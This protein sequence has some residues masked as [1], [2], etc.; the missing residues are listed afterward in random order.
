MNRT[1]KVL[2]AIGGIFVLSYPGIA[3]VT[4]MT[5]ESRMQHSEQQA[6]DQVPYLTLVKREYDRGVYRSTEVATYGLHLPVPTGVKT[7]AGAALFPAATVT[8]VSRIQ[9]GPFPGLHGPALAVIDSTFIAPPAV[10]KELAGALGSKPLL[11]AHTTVG[12][13]GGATTDL[14]SPAF[15]LVLGPDSTLA[16]EGLTG[17]FKTARHLAA[18]SG[19]LSIPR[20]VFQS[21]QG[22]IQL[23]GLE[24]SGSHEKA[25]DGLYLGTGTLTLERLGAGSASPGGGFSLQR[26]SVTT[27][28]K[29]EG[30]F[31]D[32]RVDAAADA[33]KVA[34]VQLKNV[35]YSE[36]LEHLH[37]PSF[38]SMAQAIRK[39]EQQAGTNQ[40]QAQAGIQDAIRQ[41]GPDLLSHDPVLDIRQ[42]SFA[43]PEGSF[44]LAAK[45]SAPGLS[46]A[47][48][49]W[50]A[51]ILALRTHAQV[52]ADLKVDNGLVQKLLTMGGANPKI[53]AQLTSFEQ[54]GYLTAGSS[55]VTTHLEYSGGRLT[56]N[57][58][59]FPP[60]APVN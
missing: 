6:L 8:I 57:G 53:A 20:F 14:T 13:F 5:I 54:Q 26:L 43:M 18:W 52:T 1:T 55:A 7:A 29:A 48:L 3:W 25:L 42:V 41:Y 60:A 17:T 22:M 16:W 37:G 44:L 40:P 30:E 12:L 28:S 33:A 11:Q 34:T 27:T 56:F 10:Q 4:G 9:H 21:A 58:H 39:A 35:T 32:M 59:A 49:Q 15:S 50:P 24:Y 45:I 36:S 19:Q 38:I 47:D 23:A 2:L 46:R 31:F 51:A